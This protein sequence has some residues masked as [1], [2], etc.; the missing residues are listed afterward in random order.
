[1]AAHLRRS[2]PHL[3]FIDRTG[4]IFS[5]HALKSLVSDSFSALE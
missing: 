4:K 2:R 5:S 1:M 3:F